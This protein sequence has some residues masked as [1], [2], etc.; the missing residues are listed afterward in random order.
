MLRVTVE[1]VPFG[2][3][4]MKENIATMLIANVSHGDNPA[5]YVSTYTLNNGLV[6][7]KTVTNHDRRDHVWSLVKAVLNSHE[8]GVTITDNEEYPQCVA[9]VL[10]QRTP[11]Y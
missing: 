11:T 9:D 1:L 10:M 7:T 6:A 3:E 5:S 8:Y 2:E 4:S